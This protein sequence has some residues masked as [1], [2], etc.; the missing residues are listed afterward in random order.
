[1]EQYSGQWGEM[2]ELVTDEMLHAFAV[3]G[4]Y[5]EIAAEFARRYGGLVDEAAFTL[6]SEKPLNEPELRRIVR[7]FRDL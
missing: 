3:S 4:E 2:G 5:D 7:G 1:M 6:Y